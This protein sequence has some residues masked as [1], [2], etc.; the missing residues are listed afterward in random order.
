MQDEEHSES[1]DSAEYQSTWLSRKTSDGRRHKS[2]IDCCSIGIKIVATDLI[3][4]KQSA[5]HTVYK[6][7]VSPGIQNWIVDRRF[8]DFVLLDQ[9]LHKHF[10][11]VKFPAL[12]PKRFFGSSTEPKFVEERRDQLEA[13]LLSLVAMQECWTTSDLPRFLDNENN[14]MLFIWNLE[15]VAKMQEVWYMCPHL[16]LTFVVDAKQYEFEKQSRNGQIDRGIKC[17]SRSG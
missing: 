10:P 9:E 4:T 3:T 8:N 1:C 12:P 2:V 11:S 5:I 6:I 15:R 7:E 14:S 16:F 13:Y 17:I